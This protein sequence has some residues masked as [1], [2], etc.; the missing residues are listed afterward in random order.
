MTF[1]VPVA[2]TVYAR[3]PCCE[4][5]LYW[6]P[7]TRSGVFAVPLDRVLPLMVKV[8]AETDA[9][10]RLYST[11]RAHLWATPYVEQMSEASVRLPK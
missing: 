4:A 7:R 3:S 1:G 11:D 6:I 8:A 10:I 2:D 9:A 5:V